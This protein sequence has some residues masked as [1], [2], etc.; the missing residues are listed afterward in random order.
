MKGTAGKDV[1]TDVKGSGGV[2]VNCSLLAA[3]GHCEMFAVSSRG[4]WGRTGRL[5]LGKVDGGN[6]GT[7]GL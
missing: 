6:A 7:R 4:C 5:D 2:K 1:Q 3:S